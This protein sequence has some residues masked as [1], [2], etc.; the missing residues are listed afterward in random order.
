MKTRLVCTFFIL[1]NQEIKQVEE[2]T[3]SKIIRLNTGF[4]NCP[5]NVFFSSQNCIGV[6]DYQCIPRLTT[7]SVHFQQE[8]DEMKREKERMEQQTTILIVVA[9]V[10]G[11][12]VL[13]LFLIAVVLMCCNSRKSKSKEFGAEPENSMC[14]YF[15]CT[16]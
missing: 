4:D 8:Y 13:C 16:G 7:S 3:L 2:T 15:S 14:V 6:K 12:V 11:G 5:E 9:A 1:T 10:L